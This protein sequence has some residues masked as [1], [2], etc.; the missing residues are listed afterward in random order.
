ML[1]TM[2]NVLIFLYHFLNDDKIFKWES[3]KVNM[4]QIFMC[5]NPILL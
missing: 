1:G 2:E 5:S 3:I 4:W